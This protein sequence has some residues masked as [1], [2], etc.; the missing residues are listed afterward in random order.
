MALAAAA[1]KLYALHDIY[2]RGFNKYLSI[3]GHY[4][5]YYFINLAYILAV[6]TIFVKFYGPGRS[7]GPIVCI[8]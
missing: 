7:R 4:F 2:I 3:N 1:N 8:T 6:D 5:T